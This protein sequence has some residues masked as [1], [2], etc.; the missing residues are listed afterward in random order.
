MFMHWKAT[1]IIEFQNSIVNF[2]VWARLGADDSLFQ[3]GH[4]HCQPIDA[5]HTSSSNTGTRPPPRHIIVYVAH[6]FEFFHLH[7]SKTQLNPTAFTLISRDRKL[8][9]LLDNAS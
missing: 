8:R 7:S 9:S 4:N 2:I 6:A 3:D 1:L 5:L